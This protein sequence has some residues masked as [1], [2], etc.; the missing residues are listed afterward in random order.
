MPDFDKAAFMAATGKPLIE[1]VNHPAMPGVF[2]R[3]MPADIGEEFDRRRALRSDGD[4]TLEDFAWLV[5]RVLCNADGELLLDEADAAAVFK[6]GITRM[7]AVTTP[8]LRMSGLT[9]GEAEQ[10]KDES[11]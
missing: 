10:K 1:P 6:W 3:E 8:T 2:V 11:A 4:A 9:K 5:T 7:S